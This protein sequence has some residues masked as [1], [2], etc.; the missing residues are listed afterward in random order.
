M[1]G[2]LYRCE[3]LGENVGSVGTSRSSNRSSSIAQS[4]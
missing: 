3:R 2:A 4:I 1:E